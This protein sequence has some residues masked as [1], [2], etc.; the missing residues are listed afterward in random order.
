MKR[1][2]PSEGH[3]KFSGN[4]RHY[5][6]ST[7]QRQRTWDEWVE[8]P[9]SKLGQS[10]NWFKIVGIVLSVLALVGTIA[11]LVIKLS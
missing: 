5:H 1:M 11:G 6:R 4:L 10:R 9:S 7:A 2:P 8:G 3:S